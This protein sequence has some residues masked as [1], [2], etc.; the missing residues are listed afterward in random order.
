MS[1][2][3]TEMS[4]DEFQRQIRQGIPAEIPPR[5][6]DN[7]SISRAPAR[8]MLLSDD[9]KR[10]AL[11]NAL[12]Y[13]PAHQHAEL[14]PEFADELARLGR[15][16]RLRYRPTYAMKARPIAD[17]P[18]QCQQAAILRFHQNNLVGWF[19]W[20]RGKNDGTEGTAPGS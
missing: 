1:A 5:P 17:Y 11:H 10:L 15:I 6:A 18:A 16:Y 4:R 20:W 12:R 13:F 8:P 19:Y 9:E 7:P 3:E 14:A 2:F